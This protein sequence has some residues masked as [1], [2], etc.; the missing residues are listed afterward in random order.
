M[1]KLSITWAFVKKY[2][3][4]AALFVGTVVAVML[5]KQQGT[6]F[7]D[8]I[9]EIENA[10]SEEL[11]KIQEARDEEKRQHEANL[12]KLEETLSAVQKQYDEAKKDFDS[13]KKKE[14]EDLVKLYKDDPDTLA[15]KLAE[16]TGFVVILP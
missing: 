12:K 14:I 3:S 16:A 6:S 9:Q 8:R 4:Y 2:W 13:K 10:H 1:T 15:K 5:L 11:K 7:Y